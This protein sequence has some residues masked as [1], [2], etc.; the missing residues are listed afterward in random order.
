MN[1]FRIA[2]VLLSIISPICACAQKV[3]RVS[4]T[5][6]FD[7][8]REVNDSLLV[9]KYQ[10]Y[11]SSQYRQT[12]IK[13]GP[14][15]RNLYKIVITDVGLN[16]RI[17]IA[18]GTFGELL[19]L[20]FIQKGDSIVL[21]IRAGINGVNTHFTGNSAERFELIQS[22]G[23]GKYETLQSIDKL[24]VHPLRMVQFAD[25]LLRTYQVTVDAM[26]T[27]PTDTK[28]LIKA[29]FTGW[30][31]TRCLA[32]LLHF[33]HIKK[34]DQAEIPR[35]LKRIEDGSRFDESIIVRSGYYTEFLYEQ[36]KLK[37]L[38]D[39]SDGNIRRRSSPSFRT[40]Y[41]TLKDT[42]TGD[43]RD[44][45]LAY[46]IAD[47]KDVSTTF[48]GVD[49][50]EFLDIIKDAKRVVKSKRYR[51]AVDFRL[52]TSGKGSR[53]FDF[54]FFDKTGNVVRLKN[55]RGKIVLLDVWANPCDACRE[56]KKM[57]EREVLPFVKDNPNFVVVSVSLNLTR[58]TWLKSIKTYSDERYVNLH[59][60]GE[61]IDHPLVKYY[62]FVGVPFLLLIDGNGKIVSG[63]LPVTANGNALRELIMKA[64]E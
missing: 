29:E 35:A 46:C 11:I 64:A 61:S 6:Y 18:S 27:T 44:K 26:R 36:T 32:M 63:T 58:D 56:F 8:Q 45:L 42:H 5:I 31:Y 43:V 23:F 12:T 34:S 41:E 21:T 53:A 15:E 16:T 20:T 49:P 1:L 60:G 3:S 62:N 19:P 48:D 28:S 13:N 30:V 55:F 24:S 4:I 51:E 14:I 7:V 52:K 54:S 39:F 9:M 59:A 37:I 38:L 57:F 25:S 50:D 22:T 40:L 10:E 47:P 17:G 2:F 33:D